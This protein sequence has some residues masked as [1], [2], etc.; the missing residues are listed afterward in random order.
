MSMMPP[1]EAAGPPMG[2]P[3]MPDPAVMAAADVLARY[4]GND[5][6][7]EI[8]AEVVDA[9]LSAGAPPAPPMGPAPLPGPEQVGARFP[10]A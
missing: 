6:A 5:Q 9:I 1:P 8:A 10:G 2:E 3:S 7:M 4:V